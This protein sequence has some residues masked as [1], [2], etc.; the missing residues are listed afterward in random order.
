MYGGD[1]ISLAAYVLDVD[2]RQAA[3]VV[4]HIV[5]VAESVSVDNWRFIR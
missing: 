4:G 2:P 5:G 3:E 1:F